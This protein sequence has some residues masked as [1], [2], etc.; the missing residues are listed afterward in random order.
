METPTRTEP[1]YVPIR[2]TGWAGQRK[3]PRWLLLAGLLI[4]VGAVLVALVHK[5]SK[6]EQASDLKGFLTDMRTATQSCAAGVSESLTALHQIHSGGSVSQNTAD[7]I[8]IARYGASQTCAPANN[9]QL[10]D[11]T[12]Y[13]VT[14]SLAAYH[15]A[16]VVN[17]LV[18]W[19]FPYAQRVQNDVANLAGAH[20]AASKATYTAALR[21]DTADMNRERAR[22]DTILRN[23]ITA[24]GATGRQARLPTL[25]G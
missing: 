10:D 8:K 4:V 15:L 19:C 11:L 25:P 17:D 14:E 16:T 3:T 5:P 22:I 23:A 9:M 13:Q 2:K 7:T 21:R 18:T 6:T 12:G 1:P 24:T 20:T